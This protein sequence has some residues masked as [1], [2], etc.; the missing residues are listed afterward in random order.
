MHLE[1]MAQGWWTIVYIGV[2]S[3][4]IGYT[5]QALGQKFA[6][7]TDATILLSMEAVFAA[8]TGFIFL[9]ETMTAVQLAGCGLILSAVIL[10]QLSAAR[11][12]SVLL[13]EQSP[14]H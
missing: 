11:R 13:K 5:L 6:P 1:G 14:L 3:T 2:L 8:L 9:E 4:A 10:T 12:R 7:P